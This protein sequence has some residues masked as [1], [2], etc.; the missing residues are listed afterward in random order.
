MH[1]ATSIQLS[2]EL[3]IFSGHRCHNQRNGVIANRKVYSVNFNL[4]SHNLRHDAWSLHILNKIRGPC[5]PVRSRYNAFLCRSV[6]TPGGGNGIPL[7]KSAAVVL[8]RSYGVLLG[9]VL[10]LKLIPAIGFLAFAAWGLEPLMRYGRT[11]FLYKSDNSWEKSRTNYLMTSYLQ[12]LLLWTG[13]T[14]ICRALDPVVPHSEVSQAVKQR[15]LNFVNSLSTVLACAH[16][17]SSLV[18]QAQKKFM[19]TSDA[20]NMGSD[21]TGKVIYTGV[22]LAALSLFMELLGFSTQ[23]LLTAGGLGT[24]VLTLAGREFFTN[25]LSGFTLHSTRPFIKGEWIQTKIEGYEV[26]GTVERVGWWSP[27]IIRGDDREAIHIPNH[28]FTVNVVKNLTQKSHWRV[29]THLAINHLDSSKINIMVSCFVKTSHFEEYLCVKEAVLLDLLRVISHHRIRLATQIRTIHKS[30]ADSD[31]DYVQYADDSIYTH[32]RAATNFPL[33]LKDSAYKI[34]PDDKVQGSTSQV[35]SNEEK[36]VKVEGASA[37]SKQD[38]KAGSTPTL[39]SKSDKDVATSIPN[40]KTNFDPQLDSALPNNVLPAKSEKQQPNKSNGD[41]LKKPVGQSPKDIQV[42]AAPST[43]SVTKPDSKEKSDIPPAVS[44]PKQGT[45]RTVASPS[46]SVSSLEENIVL[47]VA[48]E[49]SRRTLPIEEETAPSPSPA[50]SKELAASRN[51][52]GPASAGKDEK[53]GQMPSV[54]NSS[55]D[56]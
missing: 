45:E 41:K 40:P 9:N 22:W 48:L 10:V 50:G 2:S 13:T 46:I 56:D 11:I 28:K 36:D 44:Q 26:S 5:I 33:L 51:G 30:Y 4:A 39:N 34:H 47:G 32:S 25:F 21:L 53:D 20:R 16:I 35:H 29:K 1:H 12:P 6:L 18:Q 37:E 17:L 54:P 31:L 14:L 15:V 3:R 19:E 49:G 43:S 42:G 23:K 24:V 8:K 27:T 7:L 38:A 52:V 55:Q